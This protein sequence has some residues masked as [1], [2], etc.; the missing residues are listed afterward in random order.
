MYGMYMNDMVLIEPN[1]YVASQ[2]L[3]SIIEQVM[4]VKRSTI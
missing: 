1:I 4:R 2:S 3:P